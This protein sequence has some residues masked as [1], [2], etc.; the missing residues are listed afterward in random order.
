MRRC[1]VPFVAI[2]TAIT[3]LSV[4]AKADEI[5][6]CPDSTVMYVNQANRSDSYKTSCVN[7]WFKASEIAA[8]GGAAAL[9]ASAQGGADDRN[10]RQGGP[11]SMLKAGKKS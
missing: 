3:S 11:T 5:F 10:A 6:V 9:P 7:A 8:S 2:A 1:I 4:T